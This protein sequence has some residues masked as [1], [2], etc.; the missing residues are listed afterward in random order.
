MPYLQK[1]KHQFNSLNMKCTEK[2][3]RLECKSPRPKTLHLAQSSPKKYNIFGRAQIHKSIVQH[4]PHDEGQG[5]GRSRSSRGSHA[6]EGIAAGVDVWV[7]YGH[8]ASEIPVRGRRSRGRINRRS[9]GR[10]DWRSNGR[11]SGRSIRRS[12]GRSIRRSNG[13][14]I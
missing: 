2:A 9:N 1:F 8:G 6:L 5:R 4:L 7:G 12:N 10:S 3:H 11:S 13:R 14:R